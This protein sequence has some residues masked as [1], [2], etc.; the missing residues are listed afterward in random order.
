MADGSLF[1]TLPSALL[2]L[3]HNYL[4]TPVVN[5]PTLLVMGVTIKNNGTQISK[6][7]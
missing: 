7:D 5:R 6:S 1:C 4:V 2:E 3:R